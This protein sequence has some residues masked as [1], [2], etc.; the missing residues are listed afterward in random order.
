MEREVSEVDRKLLLKKTYLDKINYHIT[1]NP[2]NQDE[3]YALVRHFF[4]E[5]LKLDY[6]FTYEELSQELNKVF[7]RPKVKEHID[8]FLIRLSESEYLEENSLGSVDINSFLSEL[9]DII[10]NVISEEQAAVHE[11]N[12]LIGRLLKPKHKDTRMEDMVHINT[13]I[14]ELNFHITSGNLD[15]SKRLYV[16]ILKIYDNLHREDKKLLHES[17]NDVYERLQV[18]MKNPK[19]GVG[20][21]SLIPGSA[22]GTL[23]GAGSALQ[24]SKQQNVRDA[25][26]KVIDLADDTEYYIDAAN[27]NAAKKQYAETLKLYDALKRDEKQMLQPRLNDIYSQI[28]SLSA[29]AQASA[30]IISASK[31]AKDSK[32]IQDVGRSTRANGLTTGLD[33]AK[34]DTSQSDV[35]KNIDGT[36]DPLPS[37]LPELPLASMPGSEGLITESGGI[38]SNVSDT[39]S[40]AFSLPDDA[41][42]NVSDTNS[43]LGGNAGGF[44][45]SIDTSSN[46]VQSLADDDI[47]VYRRPIVEDTE[48][49][50]ELNKLLGE[51]PEEDIALSS[52]DSKGL[53]GEKSL[54][55]SGP[56]S[57]SASKKTSSPQSSSHDIQADT[58]LDDITG[59]KAKAESPGNILFSIPDE[60]L[61]GSI[62]RP[63]PKKIEPRSEAGPEIMK[64]PVITTS[65]AAKTDVMEARPG[66]DMSG[67]ADMSGAAPGDIARHRI[68]QIRQPQK[69]ETKNITKEPKAEIVK[70]SDKLLD[71]LK[72]INDDIVMEKFDKAK[73]SYKEALMLYRSMKDAE[74]A[75]CYNR[76]YATFKNLDKALHQRSLHNILETHLSESNNSQRT[77][78]S[79]KPYDEKSYVSESAKVMKSTTL[80]MIISA[81]EYTTRLYELIE[82]S[83]FN[84]SNNNHDIAMLKYFKA[85]EV[86]HSL[87][88]KDKKTAYHDL[89]ELFKRLSI[90][91]NTV[92]QD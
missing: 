88:A 28:Q 10:M 56:T 21:L 81:D 20:T 76:F 68:T 71:L 30:K 49:I 8:N 87:P 90:L 2:L 84:M 13:M 86:Y 5:Y 54:K 57:K 44:D 69:P 85:L 61:S 55:R 82:E 60:P 18:L 80:P 83:Y 70:H 47:D 41:L 58:I 12:S 22:S 1:R 77:M 23:S 91:K 64:S 33:A 40:Q 53:H 72:K 17:M 73:T 63:E 15:S 34:L 32:N 36:T 75:S 43:N 62:A 89:Y 19:G 6:E 35:V 92:R 38:G 27:L 11:E 78:A 79:T 26:K 74:K 59:A 46:N 25:V 66:K 29:D 14:D 67:I 37:G 24:S 39:I 16:D 45:F 9:A 3:L 65:I 52:K 7:I 48:Q 31:D 50:A 4:G 42:A 51:R